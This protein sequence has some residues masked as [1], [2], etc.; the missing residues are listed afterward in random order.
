MAPRERAAVIAAMA[1]SYERVMANPVLVNVAALTDAFRLRP[2]L[3]IIEAPVVDLIETTRLPAKLSRSP[4]LWS[5]DAWLVEAAE[6]E[7]LLPGGIISTGGYLLDGRWWVIAS[8]P[9]GGGFA[10]VARRDESEAVP[11]DAEGDSSFCVVSRGPVPGETPEATRC[12]RSMIITAVRI[13]QVLRMLLGKR[14]AIKVQEEYFISGY[15][16]LSRI[17]LFLS[18]DP[19]RLF[20]KNLLLRRI[21]VRR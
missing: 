8:G 20:A 16:I 19:R 12:R 3:H 13:A 10:E 7:Y 18:R 4:R 5:S 11:A 6:D 14:D 1:F 17:G 15:S 9:K 21:S 2:V